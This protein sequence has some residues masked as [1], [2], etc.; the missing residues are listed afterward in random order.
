M[1][2]EKPGWL[3]SG[4][5]REIRACSADKKKNHIACADSVLSL[6]LIPQLITPSQL[7]FTPIVFVFY[8]IY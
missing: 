4:V 8:N 7:R 6:E 3:L 1:D 5:G 2:H